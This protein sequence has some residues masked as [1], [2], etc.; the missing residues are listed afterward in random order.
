MEPSQ[1]AKQWIENFEPYS[2]GEP[3]I[4]TRR[5]SLKDDQ[6]VNKQLYPITTA[7]TAV[8]S[9][10]LYSSKCVVGTITKVPIPQVSSVQ[11]NNLS[12]QLP[13]AGRTIHSPHN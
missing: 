13:T 10:N 4:P 8:T 6:S 9:F 5:D 3:L 11:Q 12:S 2:M 1:I 7:P